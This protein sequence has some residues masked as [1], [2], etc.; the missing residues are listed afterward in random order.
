MRRPAVLAV[1]LWLAFLALCAGIVV[2]T[3]FTADLSAFLPRAPSA[4]QQALVDQ[5]LEG[6]ASRLV[7]VGIEGGDGVNRAELSRQLARRL[8]Q[9]PQVV[10]VSNGEVLGLEKD[11]EL[12]FSHRYLLSPAVTPERFAATGLHAAIAESIDLL[13]SPAGLMMKSLLPRDPTGEMVALLGQLNSGALASMA[14][15]AWASRDGQRALLLVQTLA[16]GSDIDAQEAA[17]ALIRQAFAEATQEL[18][19]GNARLLLS[20]PGAFAVS[21][22]AT[23]HN[24]VTRLALI[25]AGLIV[26][27]LLLIYRSFAALFLG[28][29]PVLSGALAGVAAVSLGFGQVHGITLGFGTTLIGEAVDYAIYLFIQAERSGTQSTQQPHSGDWMTRFWPTIRLGVLTSLCGF[30]SLLFSGF[31][32]LAQLGLYSIAGLA[33]AAGVTRFVLP[34]LLPRGF[35]VRDISHLG[36]WL[37]RL[38]YRGSRLRGLL[39]L[40]AFAALTVLLINQDQLWNRELSALSPIPPADLALDLSLRTDLGAPD[41]GTLVMVRG[42]TLEATL[43]TAERVGERLQGLVETGAMGGFES[44]ARF[45]PSQATQRSRQ[46]ALPERSVLR[47]NLRTALTDLPIQPA[48]LDA[49]VDDVETA[50]QQPLLDLA[51][52]SGSSLGLAVNSLLFQQAAGW[53]AMLP[54]RSPAAGHGSPGIGPQAVRQALIGMP[55]SEVLF[56]DTKSETDHLYSAYLSEAMRLSLLGLLAIVVLLA[57]TLRSPA[58]VLRVL[59]PLALSVLLVIAG[60][61]L[62]GQKMTILHLVGLLLIVAVGSNY[63]LFFDRSS[64]AGGPTPRTLASLLFANLTTVAGFGILAFSSVPVLQAIGST[65]G[66]GAVLALLFSAILSEQRPRTAGASST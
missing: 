10:S 6:V 55:P 12:L 27:L 20:G 3:T 37:A 57:F 4:E 30:A 53:S 18:G 49:F 28:L 31:P 25:S 34:H 66:P 21:S 45:L 41:A 17:L 23:I 13:S 46:A 64:A 51:S 19:I 43:Q 63:A 8:R 52:L 11:R 2:R 29:L 9:T 39:T 32:G 58:R 24:E 14:H 26:T 1:A 65:V 15:G 40:L 61:S 16:P 62:A 60:L 33:V 56:I 42:A 44:P 59:L 35:C 22:R 54:L 5:L 7:L 47:Q 36:E 48:R 50:R 38:A